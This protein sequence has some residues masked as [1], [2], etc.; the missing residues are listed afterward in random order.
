MNTPYKAASDAASVLGNAGV[1][2]RRPAA[3]IKGVKRYLLCLGTH[4]SCASESSP[5]SFKKHISVYSSLSI[6]WQQ[7]ASKDLPGIHFCIS[8]LERPALAALLA[9]PPPFP[10]DH[11]HPGSPH[12]V[13]PLP[14]RQPGSPRP[15][16]TSSVSTLGAFESTSRISSARKRVPKHHCSSSSTVQKTIHDYQDTTTTSKDV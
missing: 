3:Q 5:S 8:T 7:L 15:L 12:A 14:P 6:S 11:S 16:T 10:P 2:W 1:H 4:L 9:P 13:G